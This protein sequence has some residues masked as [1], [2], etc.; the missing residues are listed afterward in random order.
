LADAVEGLSLN[1]RVGGLLKLLSPGE[2]KARCGFVLERIKIRENAPQA[3]LCF[4]Q[5]G[6]A[7]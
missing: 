3:D 5:K 7:E 2:K 6:I 1:W 4:L